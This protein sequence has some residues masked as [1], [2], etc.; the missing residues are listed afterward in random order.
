MKQLIVAFSAT[1]TLDNNGVT[2]RTIKAM[3]PTP[4]VSI[5]DMRKEEERGK[6]GE[7]VKGQPVN[8][9]LSDEIPEMFNKPENYPILIRFEPK[10]LGKTQGSA[11]SYTVAPRDLE[12]GKIDLSKVAFSSPKT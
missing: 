10:D 2:T 1:K 11:V 6:K 9:N 12:Y 7:G 8:L 5:Y 3:S 4:A